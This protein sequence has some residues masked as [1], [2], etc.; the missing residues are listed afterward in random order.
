[1][2]ENRSRIP[3]RPELQL[4]NYW[5]AECSEAIRITLGKELRALYEL[6]PL[7]Q[8]MLVLLVQLDRDVEPG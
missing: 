8:Q 2:S 1:M 4:P 5:A 6:Q 7:Q 3:E